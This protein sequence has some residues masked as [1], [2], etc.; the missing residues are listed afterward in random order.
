[1]HASGPGDL[2]AGIM[3]DLRKDS[4]SCQLTR[5]KNCCSAIL[6]YDEV[7][8]LSCMAKKNNRK[9]KKSMWPKASIRCTKWFKSV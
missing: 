8:G 3:Q 2:R 9:K 1:M 4:T 6:V 5:E 7:D